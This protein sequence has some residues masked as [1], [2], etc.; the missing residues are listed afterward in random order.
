[1]NV[2]DTDHSRY[3]VPQWVPFSVAAASPELSSFPSALRPRELHDADAR[4]EEEF[5]GFRADP[6]PYLAAELMGQAFTLGKEQQMREL[7]DF[8]LAHDEVGVVATSMAARVAGDLEL[9][10]A[11]TIQVY[12]NEIA[13]QKAALKRSGRS[14]I[15]WTERALN[16]ALLGENEKAA[17]CIT[18]ALN[19]APHD[20]YVVRSAL[21]FFIHVNEWDR[22]FDYGRRALRNG[23][24]P[25]ILAPFLSVAT[26]LGKVPSAAKAVVT[27]SLDSPLDFHFSEAREALGTMELLAGADKRARKFFKRAWA[28]P[29]KAVVSHSQWVLREQLPGLAESA[30]IDFSRS[31]QAMSWIYSARLDF[32]RAMVALRKW[33]FE[34]PYSVAPY[35][36]MSWIESIEEQFESSIQTLRRG[37]V[38][39]P[40]DISLRNNMAFA[41]LK[42]GRVAEAE[43]VFARVKPAIDDEK[44]VAC[45]ATYGLLLM[46]KRENIAGQACYLAAIQNAQK[47]G[48]RRLAL[49]AAI[50]YLISDLDINRV[51]HVEA[52]D[53]LTKAIRTEREASVIAAGEALK[54]RLE[55]VRCADVDSRIRESVERF[56]VAQV[57]VERAFRSQLTP[58]AFPVAAG[59]FDNAVTLPPEVFGPQMSVK[60]D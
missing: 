50:N 31:A 52:L 7:A 1:M 11:P 20:R 41:L 36:Q 29:S 33:T 55:R 38:A 51:L 59:A 34:E 54:R 32:D 6:A 25:W 13:A 14:A 42:L 40:N 3:V 37:L 24:D 18:I 57:G 16:Y 48:S 45:L 47:S 44:E 10:S 21:R 28:D 8:V 23:A 60:L 35:M 46:S 17:R 53:A 49:R 26:H 19:L 39:N 15:L 4:F 30:S 5:A 27:D 43:A 2:V 12:R 56:I 9:T 22:A 58:E